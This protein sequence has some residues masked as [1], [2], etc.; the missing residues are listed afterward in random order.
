MRL[1]ASEGGSPLIDVS[2]LNQ[3]RGFRIF[4][5]NFFIGQNAGCAHP[6]LTPNYLDNLIRLGLLE[7]PP[8]RYILAEGIYEALTDSKELDTVKKKVEAAKD[9][10]LGFDKK[11]I[12]LTDLGKQFCLACVIDKFYNHKHLIFNKYEETFINSSCTVITCRV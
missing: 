6:E 12:E 9:M 1:F 11:K 3:P 2:N 8:N 7:I 10:T 4:I 5:R